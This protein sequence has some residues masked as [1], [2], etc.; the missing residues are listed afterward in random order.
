MSNRSANIL[1]NIISSAF[2][3][4]AQKIIL[5][6][7][8]SP[9][10]TFH[11]ATNVA[12]LKGWEKIKVWGFNPKIG[13]EEITKKVVSETRYSMGNYEKTHYP[14]MNIGQASKGKGYIFFL[15]REYGQSDFDQREYSHYTLYKAPDWSGIDQEYVQSWVEWLDEIIEKYNQI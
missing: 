14:A 4:D 10:E 15:V 2:N 1:K 13:F 3:L 9:Q 7:E 11:I 8:M 5:S 6:G 12:H